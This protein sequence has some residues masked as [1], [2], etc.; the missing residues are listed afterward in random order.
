[1]NMYDQ[2]KTALL[3]ELFE[4]LTNSVSN[5]KNAD[6]LSAAVRDAVDKYEAT[7]K[8]ITYLE[9]LDKIISIREDYDSSLS[10][11]K[12]EQYLSDVLH[13]LKNI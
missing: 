1:M 2:I 4:T 9:E 10:Q 3:K 6:S 11:E 12:L 13:G 7:H 8:V 5:A